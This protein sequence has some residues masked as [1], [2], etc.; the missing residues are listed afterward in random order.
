[1][2]DE[3]GTSSRSHTA[4]RDY[5]QTRYQA[6]LTEL[7]FT[8]DQQVVDVCHDDDDDFPAQYAPEHAWV[9]MT[10]LEPLCGE[11]GA[12]RFRP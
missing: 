2:R 9:G 5:R 6:L 3:D 11:F 1:M 4:P 12:E 10:L 8:R 7:R